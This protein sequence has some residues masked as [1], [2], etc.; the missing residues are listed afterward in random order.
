MKKPFFTRLTALV[1][2]QLRT[3][4]L[5]PPSEKSTTSNSLPARVYAGR[6]S[7]AGT[8]TVDSEARLIFTPKGRNLAAV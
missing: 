8:V 4:Y 2:G 3:V 6:R 1:N 7:V 5:Y